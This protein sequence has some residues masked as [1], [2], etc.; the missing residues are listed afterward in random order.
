[1]KSKGM[2][3][4]TD[5]R[6]IHQRIFLGTKVHCEAEFSSRMVDS[7]EDDIDEALDSDES[8]RASQLEGN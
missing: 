2:D 4:S 7:R 3:G 8:R 5:R 6:G 1:M